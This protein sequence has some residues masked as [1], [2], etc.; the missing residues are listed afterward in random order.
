MNGNVCVR[1]YSTLQEAELALL[2]LQSQG[3]TAA[4]VTEEPATAAAEGD[5]AV[6]LCVLPDDLERATAVLDSAGPPDTLAETDCEGQ[7]RHR[8]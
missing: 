2:S 6:R 8:Y 7:L 3:I 4:I 1:T 5:N